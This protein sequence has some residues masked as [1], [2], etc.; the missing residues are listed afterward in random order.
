[1]GNITSNEAPSIAKNAEISS[2]NGRFEDF[3]DC[4]DHVPH[5]EPML[6]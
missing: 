3:S 1:M 6:T 5:A 4:G 2:E